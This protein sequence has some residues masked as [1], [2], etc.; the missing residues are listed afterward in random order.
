VLIDQQSPEFGRVAEY[1]RVRNDLAH[2]G[3]TSKIFSIP[4][5]VSDLKSAARVMKR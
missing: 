3:V 4:N 2:E 5:V 1:Y